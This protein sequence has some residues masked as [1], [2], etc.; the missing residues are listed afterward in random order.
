MQKA[1]LH[2]CLAELNNNKTTVEIRKNWGRFLD[3]DLPKH[4]QWS[5]EGNIRNERIVY[6]V[7]FFPMEMVVN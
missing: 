3:V 6:A 4:G 1:C 5:A 7:P 2:L